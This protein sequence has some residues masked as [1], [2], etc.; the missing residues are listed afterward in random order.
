MY[1]GLSF[2]TSLNTTER[3]SARL[4]RLFASNSI[5]QARTECPAMPLMGNLYVTC[6]A[7]VYTISAPKLTKICLADD[8]AWSLPYQLVDTGEFEA[9]GG[10]TDPSDWSSTW[11]AWGTDL[12]RDAQDEA[13]SH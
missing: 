5:V 11:V 12:L 8:N 13:R 9:I 7:V 6:H 3:T 10:H 2:M 1:F 4:A